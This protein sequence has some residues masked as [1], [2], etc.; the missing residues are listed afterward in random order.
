MRVERPSDRVY[1]RRWWTLAVL[2]LAAFIVVLDDTILT[3][4][5]P[6]LQRELGATS[7][8]LQWILDSY[9]LVFAGLLLAA[10]SLGDRFGRK[11]ALQ[12]GL[13][14]FG[15]ASLASALSQNPDQLI[16]ARSVMGLGAAFIMPTTLSI[17]TNVFPP[18]ERARAIGIWSGVVGLG[19]AVGPLASGA[20]LERFW[21]GSVFMLNVPITIVGL[22]VAAVLVPDS[23][24]PAAPPVDVPGT[25]LSVAGLGALI[26]AII[27]AP[28]AGWASTRTLATFAAAAAL[29]ALFAAWER[30]AAHPMLDLRFFRS[31]RFTTSAVSIMLAFFALLG[32]L[33][34][35]TQHLQFYLGFSPLGAG[36]RAAPVAF[37]V[38]TGA[39]IAAFTVPRLGARV[40]V[41]SGLLISAVGLLVIAGGR[42][43]GYPPLLAG[44]LTIGLGMGLA[45]TPATDAVMGSLPRARAGVGSAVND[46]TRQ[47]GAAFGVAVVGSVFSSLYR[48]AMDGPLAALPPPLREIAADSLG[49]ALSVAAEAGGPTSDALVASARAAFLDAFGWSLAITAAVAAAAAL[50][51][52]A[53]LPARETRTPEEIEEAFLAGTLPRGQSLFEW[54]VRERRSDL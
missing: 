54:L 9:L 4:A 12:I 3:I 19:I 13:L 17:L 42:E 6:A 31:A 50:L 23:R 20:L 38:M 11:G 40:L 27:E 24:D 7:S 28:S 51:A 47:I 21:W 32:L 33:F 15:G 18:D 46:T 41:G 37:A 39:L 2:D 49:A 48:D 14:V 16:A 26:F 53:L 44:M 29:L 8:Q 36:A 30:S 34:M 45:M 22:A 1:A 5:L 10:G 35:V 43:G 25:V 52:F